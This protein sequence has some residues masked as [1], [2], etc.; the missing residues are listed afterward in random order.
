MS[1]NRGPG[2]IKVYTFC[3]K[4]VLWSLSGFSGFYLFQDKKNREVNCS[5]PLLAGVTQLRF[6][7]VLFGKSSCKTCA[8]QV[9]WIVK[10]YSFQ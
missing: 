6:D 4:S 3:P 8:R 7:I 1:R 5:H 9:G 10:D 2:I